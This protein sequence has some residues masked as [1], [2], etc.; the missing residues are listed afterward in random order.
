M[1]DLSPQT[2]AIIYAFDCDYCRD[3][4]AAALRVL[5]DELSYTLNDCKV[6]DSRAVYDLCD[7]IEKL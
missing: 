4:L 3:E 7:E 6:I 2:Q 1:T 5:A